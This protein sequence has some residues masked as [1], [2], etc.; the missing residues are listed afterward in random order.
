M[1]GF[2]RLC[3]DRHNARI[4]EKLWHENDVTYSDDHFSFENVSLFP[5]PTGKIPFW[6]GGATPASARRPAEYC[7]AR[8]PGRITLNA[9]DRRV[10][11]MTELVAENGR[12][13]PSVS[14]VSPSTYASATTA[15]YPASNY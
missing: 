5:K 9:I 7:D 4:F 6:Y 3:K 15:G 1:V 8:I 14:V 2:V 10:A 13:M 11:K 12:P